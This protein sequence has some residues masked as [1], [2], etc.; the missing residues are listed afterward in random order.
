LA[1]VNI[2]WYRF[3]RADALYQRFAELQDVEKRIYSQVTSATDSNAQSQLERIRSGAGAVLAIRARDRAYAELRNA[4]GAIYQAAGLDPLPDA[5]PD[6]DVATLASAIAQS[7]QDL[8]AGRVAIPDLD[9]PPP[10]VPVA[11]APSDADTIVVAALDVQ[12]QA[13]PIAAASDAPA[14]MPVAETQTVENP[15]TRF[16]AFVKARTQNEASTVTQ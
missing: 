4:Q 3:A 6:G 2:A 5:L 11:Q 16:L 9:A 8:E 7:M 12:P 10:A 15:F 14:E 13:E 1:Q